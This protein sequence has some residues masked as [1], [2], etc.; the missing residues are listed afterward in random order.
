[1]ITKDEIAKII[2]LKKVLE[3]TYTLDEIKKLESVVKIT[4][5][6]FIIAV[7]VEENH[8]Q[9]NLNC[10][11]ISNLINNIF[12]IKFEELIDLAKTFTKKSDIDFSINDNKIIFKGLQDKAEVVKEIIASKESPKFKIFSNLNGGIID[13]IDLLTGLLASY[14]LAKEMEQVNVESLVKVSSKDNCLKLFANSSSE[15]LEL[16]YVVSLNKE[17]FYLNKKAIKLLYTGIQESKAFEVKINLFKGIIISANGFT[18]YVSKSLKNGL[19]TEIIVDNLNQKINFNTISNNIDEKAILLRTASDRLCY[20]EN[21]SLLTS[22][23]ESI[24]FS[25]ISVIKEGY[26]DKRISELLKIKSLDIDSVSLSD[27]ANNKILLLR[28]S[29]LSY[30]MLPRK[31]TV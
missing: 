19:D 15:I 29:F 24:V 20:I 30:Y 5:N 6:E 27:V 7:E 31:K 23:D 3:S 14:K 22:N 17:D 13:S 10:K 25:P 12:V 28:N 8:I 11:F 16:K 9:L 1:M 18:V 2:K 21:N 26:S 4:D